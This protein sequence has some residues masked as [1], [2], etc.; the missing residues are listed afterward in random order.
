M[1][2][3]CRYKD[4]EGV[5]S[6]ENK[7]CDGCKK[8]PSHSEYTWFYD[9]FRGVT[10]VKILHRGVCYM[11]AEIYGQL[12]PCAARAYAQD[13]ARILIEKGVL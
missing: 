4:A 7:L 13:M 10:V 5:C 12:E 11:S 2:K 1:N 9:V 8:R 3:K 6:V